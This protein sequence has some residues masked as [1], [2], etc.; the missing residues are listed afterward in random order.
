MGGGYVYELLGFGHFHANPNGFKIG[1]DLP[2][3]LAMAGLKIFSQNIF[4][5]THQ[6]MY[7]Y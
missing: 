1:I 2:V 3:P 6:D 5:E 7:F 4:T